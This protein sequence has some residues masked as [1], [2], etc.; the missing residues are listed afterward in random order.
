MVCM[1]SR[2]YTLEYAGTKLGYV[3]HT[4]L[5]SLVG[6]TQSIVF[7]RLYTLGYPGT[8]PGYFGTTRACTRVPLRAWSYSG[9]YPRVSLR[10]CTPLNKHSLE[11]TFVIGHP[12]SS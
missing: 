11:A 4:R 10:V 7:S 9:M 2:L 12:V 8:K 6:Y 1:F 3:G 5:D